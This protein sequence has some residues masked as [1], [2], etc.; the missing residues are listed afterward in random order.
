MLEIVIGNKNY[1]SW[2]MR[3]WLALELT[4]APYREL[5]VPL[6]RPDT[7]RRIREI[8]PA[9]RVP[10]LRDE[11]LLVWDSLAICEYLAE[12]FPAAGLWPAE[13]GARAVARA[14]SA[15]MHSGFQALRSSLPMNLRLRRTI[16]SPAEDVLADVSRV[17]A[18]WRELRAGARGGEF[19]FGGFGI[20]DVMFA[21][22]VGRFRTYGIAL[23]G[24]EAE[25]AEAVWRH[26]AVVKWVAGAAAE[27]DA[28]PKYDLA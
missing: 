9:G 8:S 13:P 1:S 14:V 16:A 7:A 12:K 25:Y 17:R 3:G 19:L 2:S 10:V 11:G 18:I 21:P 26:P 27:Q 24:P 28:I 15:E 5:L 6:D 23:D 20:A 4:G 22:V